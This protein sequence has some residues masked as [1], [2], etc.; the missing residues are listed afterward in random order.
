MG[1]LNRIENRR[2]TVREERMEMNW[3]ALERRNYREEFKEFAIDDIEK[4]VN[5]EISDGKWAGLL[6]NRITVEIPAGWLRD[7]FD[8]DNRRYSGIAPKKSGTKRSAKG[9]SAA[10]APREHSGDN[11]E[12]MKRIKTLHPGWKICF[13]NGK[14]DAQTT[15]LPSRFVVVV[16]KSRA[17]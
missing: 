6:R 8:P 1:L 13:R 5:M 3:K 15:E 4:T 12:I 2:E 9:D 14:D 10:P 17:A 16:H 11:R 7:G